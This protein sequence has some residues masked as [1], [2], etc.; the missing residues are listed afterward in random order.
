MSADR[1]AQGYRECARLTWRHGT[2]YWWGAQLLPPAR[3]RQVY[4]VYALCRLADDIVDAPDATTPAQAE[5]TG[6]EL[7]AF[8]RRFF[9][10]VATTRDGRPVSEPV[11]AAIAEAVVAAGI[12]R[13]C[14][15]RFFAAMAM[16]L[17]TTSYETFDDL[18]GYMEGSAAVIGEMM[19]PVL[20]PVDPAARGPARALGFAFQLT[21]FIRDVGE[22]LDRGRVY[23][24]QADLRRYG[25]DPWLR[26]VT[27]QWRA[28]LAHEIDRNRELYAEADRGVA[29]LPPS[30]ARCVA[31]ARV[32]YSR[33]LL[34]IEE[35]D[36]D[37]F[38]S[39]IRV[40]RPEKLW[41]TATSVLRP[42]RMTRAAAL[43]E[44]TP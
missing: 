42:Q 28:A 4:A 44:S 5:A 40:P 35:A 1:L 38:S 26:R 39:R 22:D 8:G 34:R 23:L 14:F 37:V 30:S 20:D 9:D 24:P 7:E 3:R 11:L 19:L 32:L 16:D 33:I 17:T 36:Y 25:A 13:E 43:A 18:L 10:A 27:P 31:T 2:T 29:M 41:V 21:N 15:E 6:R 12:E